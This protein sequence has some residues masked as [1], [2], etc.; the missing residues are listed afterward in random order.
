MIIAAERLGP[1]RWRRRRPLAGLRRLEVNRGTTRVNGRLVTEGTL[2]EMSAMIARFDNGRPFLLAAGYPESWLTSLA[3]GVAADLEALGPAELLDDN[4]TITVEVVRPTE[5][6][7]DQDERP[8]EQ[9][10]SSRVTVQQNA[11]G[12][13][14]TIPPAGLRRG[15]KGLFAFS[16]VWNGFMTVLTIGVIVA[17]TTQSPLPDK[18][19]LAALFYAGFWLIG[20]ALLVAAVN[21]GRRHA[22]IDVVDNVLLINRKNLF[23]I[24]SH[25]WPRDELDSIAVG[26]SGMKVNDVP[27]LELKV[28]PGHGRPVGLF[29]GRDEPELR[30]IAWTLR[31]RLDLVRR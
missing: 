16:L 15:S 12:I 11:D 3:N 27:V 7:L 1:L 22:I 24:K 17:V 8:V 28:R 23:G 13:T 19:W 31:D 2:A 5:D 9:P 6:D 29:A 18:P 14:L 20:I 10:S 26:P 4:E 30:W 21:M 25:Q